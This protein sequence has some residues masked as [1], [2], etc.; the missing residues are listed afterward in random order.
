MKPIL[1]LSLAAFYV[2]AQDFYPSAVS[3]RSLGLGGVYVPSSA[4]VLDALAANPAGLSAL[5]APALDA[6]I[7][8]IFA[9]G[10]F[11]NSVNRDAPL[12][13][14]P[15]VMPYAAAGTGIGHSRFSVGFG[16]VPEML[17]V[18]QWH[19]VDAPGVAGTTYG[20]QFQKSAI[21]AVRA[22]AGVGVNLGHSISL[23]ATFG[24]DYNQN[25][26]EAPYIFQQ[27]PVL[28]GLKTLLNL[29]TTG[30]GENFSFGVLANPSRKVKLGAAWKSRT[31]ITS[32]GHATG[33][34]GQEFANLGLA[35]QPTFAYDAA[36]R[37]V[38]PQSALASV[39][40]QANRRWLF[41][42]QGNWINWNSA[43][44]TLPVNLTNG[45]NANINSLLGSTSLI[46]GV[47]LHWKNQYTFHGGVERV[48]TENISVRAG[49]E[50][51]N[52]PVPD[53][54]LSPLTAAIMKNQL[55]AGIGY[56]LGRA[57]FD[58][59]YGIDLTAKQSVAQSALLAGE[60]SNSTVS[61]GT[62]SL[63]LGTSFTF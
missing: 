23:G 19:Y 57:R 42:L 7:T 59:S 3:A 38:L 54:T 27:Q 1:F 50:H 35:F 40:W 47:P 4:G 60:Y 5:G 15:G 22:V 44:T 2:Q 31:T 30:T 46:D 49:F 63:T 6:N 18:S 48:L 13:T 43:F 21:I 34:A 41:A 11:T 51:A 25:H 29:K 28:A 24:V 53:S 26:L 20:S 14:P 33:N 37:N 9:R 39:L 61:I 56:R 55:A 62:Q 17:S 32:T 45:T 12:Q 52:S 10:S 16:I 58:L 8:S 36:V